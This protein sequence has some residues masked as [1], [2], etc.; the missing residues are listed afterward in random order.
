[1]PL[2]FFWNARLYCEMKVVA[3][4]VVHI[5]SHNIFIGSIFRFSQG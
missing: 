1:M 5:Y 4:V 3:M 2:Y